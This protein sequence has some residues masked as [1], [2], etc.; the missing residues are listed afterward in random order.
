MQSRVLKAGHS[1]VKA[2]ELQRVPIF[3]GMSPPQ[4]ESLAAVMVRRH[5]AAGQLI[6]LEGDAASG[7]WFI[8]SGRVRIIKQS[9]QGRMQGLCLV[10][11][12]KCFGG[13]PLFDDAVNPATAQ[14]LDEVVLLILPRAELQT[15]IHDDHDLADALYQ[16]FSQR[17]AHLAQLSE[18]LGAWTVSARIN[19]CLLV[20]ADLALKHPV[21]ALTHERLAELVGTVREVVTRHLSRLEKQ[22]V[23]RVE[24]GQITLLDIDALACPCL[25][26]KV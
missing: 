10:S 15:L 11:R 3:K 23:I 1:R 19:D 6:F 21:V 18:G 13:C 5:Y 17:L 22:G 25:A 2:E 8:D 7:M 16:V 20:Y 4:L 14:A 12:G 26:G 24:P 9:L